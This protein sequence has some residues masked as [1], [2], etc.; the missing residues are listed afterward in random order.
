MSGNS[1][2]SNKENLPPE[3]TDGSAKSL[4]FFRNNKPS[5]RRSE[6]KCA[7]TRIKSRNFLSNIS[8]VGINK[9]DFFNEDFILD[10]YLLVTRKLN[11]FLLDRKLNS[12]NKHEVVYMLWKECMPPE[13][14]KYICQ[15]ENF[16]YLNGNNVL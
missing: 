2:G 11:P 4:N 7:T 10:F 15:D 1:N 5:Q 9:E 12:P 6:R 8:Y 13:F 3:M 16:I 14:Y